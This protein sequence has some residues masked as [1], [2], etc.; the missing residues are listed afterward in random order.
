MSVPEE[1]YAKAAARASRRVSVDEVFAA[2]F[3]EQLDALERLKRRAERA[4][5]ETIPLSSG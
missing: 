2:A 4:D 1:P 5:K 3:G